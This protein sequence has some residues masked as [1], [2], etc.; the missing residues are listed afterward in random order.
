MHA[1]HAPGHPGVQPADGVY[2]LACSPGSSVSSFCAACR[3]GGTC[4]P[5]NMGIWITR[6]Q[7]DLGYAPSASGQEA[8]CLPNRRRFRPP[9]TIT[10]PASPRASFEP[11]RRAKP[12]GSA[13]PRT[14]GRCSSFCLPATGRSVLTRWWSGFDWKGRRPAPPSIY[15]ALSFLEALG[16]RTPHREP[17]RLRGVQ[18]AGEGHGTVFLVCERCETV[19]EV[20]GAGLERA[21][22]DSRRCVRV[23]ASRPRPGGH[24][25]VPG[26]RPG[27]VGPEPGARPRSGRRPHGRVRPRSP[28][29]I[30]DAIN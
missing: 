29:F 16:A 19:A 24:G 21:V 10:P 7:P 2:R 28:T 9:A 18:W 14:G 11:K 1:V 13:S 23:R 27:G 30:L 26:M 25:A 20:S 3:I 15:R 17:Q 12:A 8:P 4:G 22:H 6:Q 5:G